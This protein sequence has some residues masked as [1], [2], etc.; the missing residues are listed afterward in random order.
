M[1]ISFANRKLKKE[2]ES[3]PAL[4]RAHGQACARRLMARIA[5]LQAA[6]SL[7][8][9]RELPGRCEE[10]SGDRQGQLSLTL[11]DGKRLV[12][13]PEDN[14]PKTKP[15]GGLDWT[16]VKAVRLLEIDNYHRG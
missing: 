15:D 8:E 13:E 1:E 12:F 2:C 16:A 5:D 4:Q 7:V 3:Q 10:L 9:L 6:V 14:P 11:P